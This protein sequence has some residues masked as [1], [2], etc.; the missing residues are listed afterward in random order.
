MRESGSGKS[1]ILNI[2]SGFTKYNDGNV[3]IDGAAT[4]KQRLEL[5]NK[6]SLVSQESFLI[7]NESIY[8]N[9]CKKKKKSQK[10]R[11]LMKLS[12]FAILIDL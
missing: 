5:S 4:Q 11:N 1:S 7:D 8:Y 10:I 3:F 9:I 6:I 12:R 2:L